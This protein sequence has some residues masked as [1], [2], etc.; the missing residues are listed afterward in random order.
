V[1]KS[2]KDAQRGFQEDVR[3][4]P[5]LQDKGERI[6][7]FKGY[8]DFGGRRVGNRGDRFVINIGGRL[9][10][11]SDDDRRLARNTEVRYE[12]LPNN[13]IREVII[14]RNGDRIVTVRN[15]WGEIV[16]RS[17]II[18]DNREVVIFY[19]PDL[20]RGRDRLFLRDP[21]DSLP[22]MRLTIPLNDYIIDVSGGGRR[23]YEQFLDEP[24]VE[25]VE[26]VYSVGEV[27]N[28]AR[29]RDKM[30]RIDLDTI[31]FD[32]GSSDIADSQVD[33]LQSVGQAIKAIIDK[34]PG[35]TFLIEGHTDAVGTDE[36]NLVLSDSRAESVASVL[37]QAFDI[38]AENLVTQGYGERYL[39]VDSDGPERANRRVTI[40]RITP[41]VRPL[42]S[43]EQ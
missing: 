18:G 37:S 36:S 29:L 40:R 35:E 12:R 27:K 2:D 28:S 41:L 4:R 7:G 23:N 24:P 20:A 30:R 5:V 19:S 8:D 13:L 1:P 42:A 14:Q 26:R 22:P 25:Q 11:R 34:D 43:S 10:I 3:I 39:K 15:R 38:P 6:P 16:R 33:S 17:R 32:T 31:T 21:G 9:V